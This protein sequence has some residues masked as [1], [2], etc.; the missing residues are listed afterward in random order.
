MKSAKGAIRCHSSLSSWSYNI[1]AIETEL[2]GIRERLRESEE[3]L[4]ALKDNQP[5][6]SRLTGKSA[7]ATVIKGK[8][9]KNSRRGKG[10]S[11]KKRRS[12]PDHDED[13]SME[14]DFNSGSD[15]DSDGNSD[16]ASDKDSD[17]EQT[18]D[19]SGS[20]SDSEESNAG[21]S[22]ED[23]D[24][25]TEE[26]LAE[27]IKENKAAVKSS[28][29]RLSE[30]RKQRKDAVD[31][32]STLKKNIAKAQK[33]KNAFC[34]SKRSEVWEHSNALQTPCTEMKYPV[35]VFS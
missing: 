27:R 30:A 11:P 9:R 25:V 10:G 5:F 18:D 21:V 13:E 19:E 1:L 29:N 34:S 31:Y 17:D 26:D 8:K 32:L 24:E 28:R 6:T 12:S 15:S 20:G 4:E 33:E 2:K 22:D 16:F 23:Q 3:H 35:T 14:S 7:K